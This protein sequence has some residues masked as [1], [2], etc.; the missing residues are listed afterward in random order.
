MIICTTY[1]KGIDEKIFIFKQ[2]VKAKH[3]DSIG[4]L[5]LVPYRSGLECPCSWKDCYEELP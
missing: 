3:L 2:K 5:F 1:L 4:Y